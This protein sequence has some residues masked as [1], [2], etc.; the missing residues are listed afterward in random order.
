VE[1]FFNWPVQVVSEFFPHFSKRYSQMVVSSD[2]IRNGVI[3]MESF[4]FSEKR[5]LSMPPARRHKW[6]ASW[7][8][9]NYEALLR[10]RF[11]QNSL[12]RFFDNYL[13]VQSWLKEPPGAIKKPTSHGKWL[14]FVSDRFHE[15]QKKSGKG[16]A[17]ANFLPKVSR[18]D[19]EIEGPWSAAIPYRV[20]L[21]RTRSAFNVGSVLRVVDAVGFESVLL[22]DRT[23]GPEN[24]QVIKTA[25][26]CTRWI[27]QRKYKH[28]PNALSRVKKDGY[29]I[30]GVETMPDSHTYS[31][32]PWP[33]KGIVVLG[34]EE[35]GISED[36]LKVCDDFVHLPM[37]GLKNSVNVANAF[38]VIAFHIAA[39]K[40]S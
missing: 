28:L 30:I 35:F 12:Q 5:F 33:S 37:W 39:L 27:P 8:R 4:P 25:M 2:R 1:F 38:A 16:L 26:G 29:S 31:E 15:H 21:D 13:T 10:K 9:K 18:G 20:A 24:V 14:E 3:L 32:Y 23:P 34:N 7:L 36:V 22:S 6:V 11:S 17:E 19:R 40:N